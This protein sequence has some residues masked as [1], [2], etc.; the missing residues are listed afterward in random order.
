MG[1]DRNHNVSSSAS[2]TPKLVE[3]IGRDYP[4]LASLIALLAADGYIIGPQ[5]VAAYNA[6]S[7]PPIRKS[8]LV[9]AATGDASLDVGPLTVDHVASIVG[10]LAAHRALDGGDVPREALPKGFA[11]RVA[12]HRGSISNVTKDAFLRPW[13]Q[14]ARGEPASITAYT[15]LAPDRLMPILATVAQARHLT[16]SSL[17]RLRTDSFR[18]LSSRQ[19]D[20]Y[21]DTGVPALDLRNALVLLAMLID[22]DR[23]GGR[24][25][26][27][28]PVS[29]TARW[30]LTRLSLP[31]AIGFC[32]VASLIVEGLIDPSR[33]TDDPCGLASVLEDAHTRAYVAGA[34]A[35]SDPDAAD[36]ARA[37]RGRWRQSAA[38]TGRWIAT[39]TRL[40]AGVF[41][42]GFMLNAD[43]LPFAT[44][45]LA[46]LKPYYDAFD[47]VG[48]IALLRRS[49]DP[50]QHRVAARLQALIDE[51]ALGR[52]G[53]R[54]RDIGNV[55]EFLEHAEAAEDEQAAYKVLPSVGRMTLG[56][57]TSHAA[58]ASSRPSSAR[59]SASRGAPTALR[60][61]DLPLFERVMRAPPIAPA[62]AYLLLPGYS[63]TI[64]CD[65]PVFTHSV[66]RTLQVPPNALLVGDDSLP[67][68]RDPRDDA[69]ECLRAKGFDVIELHKACQ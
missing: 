62:Q 34:G 14:L 54:C 35:A 63:G 44:P 29:I 59:R 33:L 16:A 53:I 52:F 61:G 38:W 10:W 64:P 36:A 45:A 42:T 66:W 2:S 13:W 31:A 20:W 3:R 41:D 22:G 4:E 23:R 17:A 11:Q 6:S 32:D 48:W 58:P 46:F 26:S 12:A 8:L 67:W 56:A 69:I 49:P 9:R 68:A 25:Q 27:E 24:I 21:F 65:R 7:V 57:P 1:S 43:R 15:N 39:R 51:G 55:I 5:F 40:R 50:L 47:A 28:I 18:R 19:N 60:R 37:H 30:R